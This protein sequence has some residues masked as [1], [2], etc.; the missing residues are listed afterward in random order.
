MHVL[1]QVMR[2]LLFLFLYIYPINAEMTGIFYA[3]KAPTYVGTVNRSRR[4]VDALLQNI[5]V[6]LYPNG[7]SSTDDLLKSKLKFNQTINTLF[8]AW[9]ICSQGKQ[10]LPKIKY[11]S[12][13]NNPSVCDSMVADTHV[14]PNTY[15]I[16]LLPNHCGKESGDTNKLGFASLGEPHS[17]IYNTSHTYDARLLG[18]ELGHNLNL[19][20]AFYNDDEYGDDTCVMG[21][22]CK[23]ICFNAPHSIMLK[24]ISPVAINN[25]GAYVLNPNRS[26]AYSVFGNYY[27][28]YI[29]KTVY[30]YEKVNIYEEDDKDKRKEITGNNQTFMYDTKLLFVLHDAT[31][32]NFQHFRVLYD[33]SV[34]PPVILIMHPHRQHRSALYG[35]FGFFIFATICLLLLGSIAS[36]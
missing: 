21:A 33:T 27:V 29:N 9:N 5:I 28:S 34:D 14:L 36:G 31:V 2:R 26:F 3:D 4:D 17:F 1:W 25:Y 11:A 16:Y 20:H 35:F 30:I 24:W 18:H 15:Y 12:A 8:A 10:L 13:I 23:E 32:A 6:V 22:C 7:V 19:L